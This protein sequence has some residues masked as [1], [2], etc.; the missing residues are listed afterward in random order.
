MTHRWHLFFG[1][2]ILLGL[3]DVPSLAYPPRARLDLDRLHTQ[4][5]MAHEDFRKSLEEIAQFCEAR[6]L[7]LEA[8][9]IRKLA[10][11]L[12]SNTLHAENL[13]K[14]IQLEIPQNLPDE[15]RQ[16]RTR[17]RE[18]R[19][20]Y[21]GVLYKQ[22]Q[23][24]LRA[25]LVSLAYDLV[26]EVARQN[27][28]HP[29]ARQLLGYVQYNGEWVTPYAKK[30]LLKNLVQTEKF[31]WLP[32]DH[33]QRYEEGERYYESRW[34]SATK[35]AELRQ[36]FNKAWTIQTD[37]YLIKTNHSLEAGVRLGRQLEDFYRIFFSD[38][39]G[40]SDVQRTT[41]KTLPGKNRSLRWK[42]GF[43]GPLLPLAGR[44]QPSLTGQNSAGHQQNNGLVCLGRAHRP[45]F[46]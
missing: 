26:R 46:L 8:D 17:L 42:S 34:I 38:L 44:V 29:A 35:E 11:P 33:E 16:W 37:H 36:D 14:N 24:A 13:P 43:Q 1:I 40:L 22:A 45:L 12:D 6:K 10:E 28:D 19:N 9:E 5:K 41:R 4:L 31:G 23:G 15:E 25:G 39:R 21:A 7:Q 3:G 30:M 27:P 20:T 18:A 2:L 32:K